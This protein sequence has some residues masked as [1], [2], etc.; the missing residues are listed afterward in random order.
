M[1]PTPRRSHLSRLGDSPDNVNVYKADQSLPGRWILPAPSAVYVDGRVGRPTF[2]PP[3]V[4]RVC[5]SAMALVAPRQ[6]R[7]ARSRSPETPTSSSALGNLLPSAR[8]RITRKAC[9]TVLSHP[10]SSRRTRR[11]VRT[12]LPA[13]KPRPRPAYI[14]RKAKPP[15]TRRSPLPP[16]KQTPP[17]P[18]TPLPR[19]IEYAQGESGDS[20]LTRPLS[21]RSLTTA[22]PVL[23]REL[24]AFCS[25]ATST[26]DILSR[27]RAHNPAHSDRLPR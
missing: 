26:C 19:R 18:L 9:R 14:H 20:G 8:L 7:K 25:S 11:V 5:P 15:R 1:A 10:R 6:R 16:T 23:P 22:Y 13:A 3:G 21:R 12:F 27:P 24:C 4:Q 17:N 2:R